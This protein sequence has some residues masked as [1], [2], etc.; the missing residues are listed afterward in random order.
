VTD[1]TTVDA[2]GQRFH[3]D[4]EAD[5]LRFAANHG[6]EVAILP[7]S[8][9]VAGMYGDWERGVVSESTEDLQGP[10]IEETGTGR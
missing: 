1:W 9:V 6:G 4:T 8:H 5:A 3:H 10:Q 2:Y 7:P